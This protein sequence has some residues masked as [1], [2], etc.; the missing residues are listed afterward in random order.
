MDEGSPTPR[1]HVREALLSVAVWKSSI[2][3]GK[4]GEK[5]RLLSLPIAGSEKFEVKELFDGVLRFLGVS[6]GFLR[7]PRWGRALIGA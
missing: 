3:V 5:A 4:R 2:E 6:R 1:I 7:K